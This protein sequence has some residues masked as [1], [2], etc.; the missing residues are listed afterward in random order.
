MSRTEPLALQWRI[1]GLEVAGLSWGQPGE[2]PV[3]ALHGWLD[4]A[5]SYSLLAPLL[6]GYHVV[7]LDLT[8]HG[9]SDCRSPDATYQIWDDL[10]EVVGVLDALGWE[11]FSLLGHS[12][13]A[14]ISGLVA[15]TIPERVERLILLDAVVAQA[16]DEKKFPEQMRKFLRDKS[17]L[18]AGSSRVFDTIDAAVDV[19]RERGLPATA[20]RLLVERNLCACPGGFTWT[21][22][23]RLHGASAVKLT[24]GQNAAVL[25]ALVMPTLLLMAEDGHARHSEIVATAQQHIRDLTTESVAGGH[26]FHME[27]SV[28]AVAQRIALFL[29]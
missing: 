8:G 15:S 11:T 1:N 26:H 24:T 18:Q 5:A 6:V 28:A 13:G 10:P 12:R 3:L 19:R 25:Q 22:D 2:K 27:Q 16:V 14:I 20:A 23:A 29:K 7:A 9:R 17:R 4:N 21:T